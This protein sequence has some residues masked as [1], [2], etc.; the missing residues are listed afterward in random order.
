ML[1]RRDLLR[2]GALAA[3]SLG[4]APAFLRAATAAT[5]AQPGTGPYG[6]LQPP[7]ANGIMLPQGFT[8][9]VIAQGGTPLGST[10]YGFPIFPDGSATFPTPDGGWILVINSEVPNIPQGGASA[11]RFAADG[12]ITDAYRVLGGTTTN[13]AGGPT[14]W[15][16]WMSCEEI[17][18]GLVWECDPTGA[19][20]ARSYP[21][22]GVFKH[23]AVAVDPVHEQ[24]YL[25]EDLS[26]GG[27]Y[28]FTP[29]SYPDCSKGV[30][31]V[32]KVLDSGK[33]QWLRVPE[34]QGGSDNPTRKQLP[35]MTQF[36]RGEGIYYDAGFVYVATTS[37]NV[38]HAYDTR[39][40]RIS[41]LYD[42]SAIEDPPLIN[43]D[44]V[45]VS[46][47][48][49]VFVAEDNG[50]PADPLDICLI[51]PSGEVARFCKFTG[52]QHGEPGTE[53]KSEITGPSFDPSGTRL[54]ASSQRALGSGL[55]Y[56][57]S[58]PFRT[59]RAARGP[60]RPVGA[61]LGVE[62]PRRI[63]KSK[64]MRSGLPVAMTLDSESD[65]RIH[66]TAR[67]RPRRGARIRK[68]RLV[69]HRETIGAGTYRERLRPRPPARRAL[70]RRRRPLRA[71]VV[72]RVGSE[73]V[74]RTL[75]VT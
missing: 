44:N 60:S 40:G 8:S 11:I 34:P 69:R 46:R 42:A 10:G 39:S 48:G 56:E 73:R 51:T 57:I 24:I 9:R 43:P 53:A 28:R 52:P 59:S 22:M 38:V 61:A 58:G 21:A 15:G 35:D 36:K 17:D 31:E 26:D 29:E 62:V 27:F 45:V 3:G 49:D 12:T 2:S 54:Y 30:L 18:D 67:M 68:V 33:V 14:P 64:L 55:V 20:P 70:R 74:T 75:R 50:G 37:D 66:V 19:T 5:P 23:E 71:K 65:V 47:S 25:T 41:R 13:C 7:D 63:R 4:L 1:T 16:T 32:A 72:I 6:P